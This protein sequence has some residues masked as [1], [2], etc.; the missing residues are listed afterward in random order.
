MVV[1]GVVTSL[2]GGLLGSAPQAVAVVPS[3]PAAV[4]P[5]PY[6]V[7]TGG[8]GPTAV[9]GTISTQ[10][11]AKRPGQ[12]GLFG[13]GSIGATAFTT[14]SPVIASDKTF[15]AVLESYGVEVRRP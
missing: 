5:A 4:T 10:L 13:D 8:Q 3:P 1:A 12:R 7:E 11:A 15:G 9:S 6:Y 14:R 2:V